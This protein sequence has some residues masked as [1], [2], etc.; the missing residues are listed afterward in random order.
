MHQWYSPV[1]LHNTSELAIFISVSKSIDHHTLIPCIS[2]VECPCGPPTDTIWLALLHGACKIS[3]ESR[4]YVIRVREVEVLSHVDLFEYSDQAL[5]FGWI[6]DTVCKCDREEF[7][8][9]QVI[10]VVSTNKGHDGA[11]RHDDHVPSSS[12]ANKACK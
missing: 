11:L 4:R 12:K 9:L 7:S 1:T 5:F 6:F 10:K 2:I 8:S 3:L